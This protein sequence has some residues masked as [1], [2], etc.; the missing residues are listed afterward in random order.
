[1][2]NLTSAGMDTPEQSQ[3]SAPSDLA[4][5]FLRLKT[6]ANG[7]TDAEAQ[8][9]LQTSGS[10]DPA[11]TR[12]T[13]AA[14]QIL[15]F[16]LNPLVTILLLAS[17]VAAIAGDRLN[18]SIIFVLVLLSVVLNFWQTFR[19]QKAAEKLRENVAPMASALRDGEWVML[20]RRNMVPGDII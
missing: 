9:R 5:Q 12:R 8:R 17:L 16:F 6:T 4:E 7:L 14:E 19:S 11:S 20:P 2:I 15:R 1:M 13:A 3:P 18:A 10:N